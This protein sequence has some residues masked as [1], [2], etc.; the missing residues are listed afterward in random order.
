[1]T[2]NCKHISEVLP[3]N[4]PDTLPADTEPGR[5][6]QEELAL[7]Q[8]LKKLIIW[9]IDGYGSYTAATLIGDFLIETKTYK[10]FIEYLASFGNDKDS[11]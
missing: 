7:L 5:R 11:K 10:R 2:K 9:F 8:S 1:M 4:L 3:K 6:S